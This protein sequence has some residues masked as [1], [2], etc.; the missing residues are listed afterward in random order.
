MQDLLELWLKQESTCL[1]SPIQT[2]LLPKNKKSYL[3][4]GENKK[5]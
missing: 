3:K 4:N 2:S 5:Y 1:A